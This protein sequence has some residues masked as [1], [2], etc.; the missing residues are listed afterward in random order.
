[1]RVVV[2]GRA[3]AGDTK[4]FSNIDSARNAPLRATR[5][6][7]IEAERA[8]KSASISKPKKTRVPK[9]IVET[10]G[11]VSILARTDSGSERRN[12]ESLAR[13]KDGMLHVN[14]GGKYSFHVTDAASGM[15]VATLHSRKSAMK[16]LNATT[17]AAGRVSPTLQRYMKFIHARKADFQALPLEELRRLYRAFDAVSELKK[18]IGYD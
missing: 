3:N 10:K 14:K 12:V 16:F 18:R 8:V 11:T 17:N 6:K 1:M 2:G 13:S 4:L 9:K 15:A 7:E 5:A